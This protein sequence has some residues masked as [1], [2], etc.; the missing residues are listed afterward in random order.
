MAR[1]GIGT[2]KFAIGLLVFI[3]FFCGFLGALMLHD[4]DSTHWKVVA[5]GPITLARAV[6]ENPVEV[7]GTG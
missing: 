4:L 1:R 7:P 2:M 5:K 6:N 3:W